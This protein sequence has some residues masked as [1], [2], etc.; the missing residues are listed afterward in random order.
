MIEQVCSMAL[1]LAHSDRRERFSWEDIVEA[2]TTIESGMAIKI[3]YVPR[4]R[5]PW[6]S[7]KAGHGCRPCLH[8]GAEST[9]LSIRRRGDALGHHQALEGRAL[10]LLAER[11]SGPPDLDARSDGRRAGVLRENSTGV[12]G[13][14]QSATARAA[15]MVGACAMAPERIEI[16]GRIKNE[17][18]A[19]RER[20]KIARRFEGIGTQIMNRSGGGGPMEHDPLSGV[21][22]DRDKRSMACQLIGQAY[23]AAH[24]LIE[25]N[26]EAV[27]QIA[28]VLVEQK[29]IARRRDRRAPRL[30][31]AHASLKSTSRMRRYGRNYEQRVRSRGTPRA[32]DRRAAAHEAANHRCSR[33]ALHAGLSAAGADLRWGRLAVH[34]PDRPRDLAALVHF[35]AGGRGARSRRADCSHVAPNYRADGEQI[36]LVEAQ[37]PIVQ[38]RVVDAIAIARDRIRPVGRGYRS[39]EP[40]TRTLFYVFCSPVQ[41]DCALPNA[42]PEHITFCNENRW[43][44]PSTPSST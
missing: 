27:E 7:T 1:T 15:W 10:Q 37:P 18:D 11:G 38:N 22:M 19:D 14:V 39:F 35:Q 33:R 42:T 30:V 8:E 44:S 13:D 6:P 3:E 23:V 34:V 41:Q 26:R 20:K 40:A 24:L 16:N 31:Q 28:D 43:S 4:R 29:G 32:R 21:M 17:E 2:M 25:H 9:R 36:A 5:A 12:G